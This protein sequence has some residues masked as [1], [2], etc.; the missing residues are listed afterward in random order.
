MSQVVSC[1]RCGL[2][3]ELR[4]DLCP[5]MLPLCRA[6]A[7][8][9]YRLFHDMDFNTRTPIPS[10]KPTSSAI[11]STPFHTIP[12]ALPKTGPNRSGQENDQDPT[13]TRYL[14]QRRHRGH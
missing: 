12:P 14:H 4:C 8:P 10:D 9:H 11:L 5:E 6:C 7:T 2:A 3:S 1:S 13:E